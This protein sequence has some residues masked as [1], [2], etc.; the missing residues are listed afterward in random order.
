MS[1]V[2]LA[3]LKVAYLVLLWVFVLLI[4]NTVRT[5]LFGRAASANELAP[6][7]A[8]DGGERPQ[9]PVHVGRLVIISGRA[10]GRSVPLDGVITIGRAADC[11]LDVDDDYASSRHARLVPQADGGWVLEDLQSTN[12]TSVNGVRIAGPVRVTSAD[13][14]R[15]GRSQLRLED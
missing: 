3:V 1:G 9:P 13:V 6:S 4:A 10:T 11:T 8:G 14:I 7:W 12:G 15:I 2:L 5:D